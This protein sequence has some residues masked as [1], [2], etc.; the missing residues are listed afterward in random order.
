LVIATRAGYLSFLT[1]FLPLV[2]PY[3]PARLERMR[4]AG[5]P[6]RRR[7]NV[8]TIERKLFALVF[9]DPDTAGEAGAAL[10]RAMGEDGATWEKAHHRPGK[11]RT[12]ARPRSGSRDKQEPDDSAA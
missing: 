5:V 3:N 11:R 12:T 9:D 1:V 7:I 4:F 10:L 6:A 2:S 8:K